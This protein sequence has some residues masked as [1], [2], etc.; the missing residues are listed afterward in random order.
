MYWLKACF[1]LFIF[2]VSFSIWGQEKQ[3]IEILHAEELVYT[4]KSDVEAQR[5]IGNV[6]FR[7]QNALMYCD[8]AYLYRFKNQLEAFGN[9][10][11]NQGDTL[12]L[13]GDHL[14][15]DGDTQIAKVNG[16][17]VQLINPDFTLTSTELIYNRQNNVAD[18]YSGAIIE[19]K[20]DSNVLI[21]RIGHYFADLQ[22]FTFKDSVV[23]TN[24]N[25]VMHSDTL[26]YFSNTELVNFLGPTTITGD[27]NLIYCETGWYDTRKDQSRYFNNAYI[28]TD[29]RKLEGDTLFYDRV[30]GYG[31]ADGD[32]LITD[33]ANNVLISGQHGE[34]FENQDSAVISQQPLM[35]Q[36]IEEDSLFMH[37]DTF[38]FHKNKAEKQF[39]LAYHKV[40]IF[41]SDL[42]GKCDSIAYSLSD[43]IVK[44]YDEP[45][46]WS[47]SNQLTAVRIDIR[48]KDKK[49]HSIF[50][51][52]DAFIVSEIDSLRYNQIKG[53]E[54]TGY[55]KNSELHKIAVR[56][57]GE[58]TY[59]GQDE[60]EKFIGVNVAES[61]DIDITL[62]EH[63]INTISFINQPKATM[64]PM[65]ELDP[66]KDLRYK[67]FKW[68]IHLR[69]RTKQD[70]FD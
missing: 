36:I 15:Y 32:I 30:I 11:I 24:P 63:K 67:G 8:S 19:S 43:S 56:G 58:T 38:K 5:L 18:Y 23:L 42:Q 70:I 35:V 16:D 13:Y 46:L 40:K 57:N 68:L 25:F 39:M 48:M 27:S 66:V 47:D 60:Q 6:Q 29:G 50:L 64:Y 52:Q 53:K 37:A 62:K 51:E 59:Y 54:M 3:K 2:S 55:F 45:V 69:P 61:S 34:I 9:I 28:I 21:S 14:D 1:L 44:L 22:L 4:K 41:K 17:E 10:R 20:N 31:Q 26:K 7:H 12:N 65:G 33:T 49:I